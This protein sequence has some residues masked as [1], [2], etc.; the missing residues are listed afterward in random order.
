MRDEVRAQDVERAPRP[1]AAG[2]PADRSP[3]APAMTDTARRAE[4]LLDGETASFRQEWESVQAGFVDEPRQA[5]ERADELVA[6]AAQRVAEQLAHERQQL[7]EH[8]GRGGDVSTEDLRVALRL[9]RAFFE[10]LLSI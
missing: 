5:V 1:D 4:S 8:W 3:E 2:R 9:Y 10:R 6:R 7:E